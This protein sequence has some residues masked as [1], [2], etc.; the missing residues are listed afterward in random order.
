VTKGSYCGLPGVKGDI[1]NV[2]YGNF[3]VTAI[4]GNKKQ[5]V[6][7]DVLGAG[8]IYGS[9]F[10]TEGAALSYCETVM[11]PNR[12][13]GSYLCL[14]FDHSCLAV[15]SPNWTE[16]CGKDHGNLCRSAC[17]TQHK[18]GPPEEWRGRLGIME[19][20]AP[21]GSKYRYYEWEC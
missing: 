10:D 21:S 5:V 19:F 13:S 18:T 7:Y 12:C 4:V 6:K 17:Q 1:S 20:Y 11:V 16:I 8:E 9:W 2:A 3:D 14:D 15:G